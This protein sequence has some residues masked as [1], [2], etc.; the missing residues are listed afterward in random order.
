MDLSR[1][2]ALKIE[3]GPMIARLYRLGVTADA[4]IAAAPSARV[5]KSFFIVYVYL[6]LVDD[7]N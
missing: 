6:V 1:D 5:I 3:C 4:D 2:T 7:K